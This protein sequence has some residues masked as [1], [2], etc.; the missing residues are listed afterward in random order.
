MSEYDAIADLIYAGNQLERALKTGGNYEL[1]ITC[2]AAAVDNAIPAHLRPTVC[3]APLREPWNEDQDPADDDP[4]EHQ[5]PPDALAK[6][7]RVCREAAH[8]VA[9]IGYVGNVDAQHPRVEALG[10]ALDDYTE[11]DEADADVSLPSS[12]TTP[13]AK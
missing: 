7:H 12:G 5:E 2:W 11:W 4:A 8:L 6:A 10:A 1:A 9:H 3:Y 13:G